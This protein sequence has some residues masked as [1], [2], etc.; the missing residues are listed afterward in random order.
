MDRT[1]HSESTPTAKLWITPNQITLARIIVSVFVFAALHWGYYGTALVL[2]V[3]AAGT[4]WIDGYLARKYNMVSQ[5]GRVLDP[6]ADK[7][8]ICGTFVFLSSLFTA[9]SRI[10][11]WM[12]VVIVARELAVT[13]VRS[14]LELHG[15][16]FSA[17]MPG[18]LKMVFQCLAAPASIWLLYQTQ[19]GNVFQWLPITVSALAWM[20]TL[21]TVYSGV[22]YFSPAAR[23]FREIA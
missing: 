8:I 13:V 1:D 5:L 23:L 10:P 2:F 12:T 16:D 7:I 21:M 22:V 17:N 6:I 9:G 4:D 3:L 18:K 14:F 11:A 20:A 15:K 19:Q